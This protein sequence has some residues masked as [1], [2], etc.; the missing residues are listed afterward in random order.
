MLDLPILAYG[1]H[2]HDALSVDCNAF[3]YGEWSYLVWSYSSQD[4]NYIHFS[5]GDDVCQVYSW[6]I[7]LPCIFL[8]VKMGLVC[9]NVSAVLLIVAFSGH[10]VWCDL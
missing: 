4:A 1:P 5:N 2:L 10:F 8:P 3:N 7:G 6:Y 9:G